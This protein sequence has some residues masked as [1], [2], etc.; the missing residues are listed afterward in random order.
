VQSGNRRIAVGVSR[1]TIS[2]IWLETHSDAFA[3]RFVV[4]REVRGCRSVVGAHHSTRDMIQAED[5][6]GLMHHQMHEPRWVRRR[7]SQVERV[8]MPF[9]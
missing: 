7:L 6:A 4:G 8:M 5:M 9:A 2:F 1:D 3:F